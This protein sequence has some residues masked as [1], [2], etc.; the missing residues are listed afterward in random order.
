LAKQIGVT[1][2]TAWFMLKRIEQSE[3]FDNGNSRFLIE[4]GKAIKRI[5]S[6]RQ[7]R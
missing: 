2:K 7:S 3:H 4:L 6:A 5:L 1:Q